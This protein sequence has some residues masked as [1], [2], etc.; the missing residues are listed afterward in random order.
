M[1]SSGRYYWY[2]NVVPFFAMVAVECFSVGSSV[3]FKAATEKGLSYY[4]F[5]AYSYAISTFILLL[6]FP[7]IFFATRSSGLPTFK[8]SLV[9]RIFLLGLIGFIFQLIGYKGLEFSSPT[10]ASALSNLIPAFTYVLAILFR[11]EKATLKSSSTQAKIIGSIVSIIGALVVTLY[12]GPIVLSASAS[13]SS[14]LS[15]SSSQGDWVLGAFLLAAS[16]TL[17]PLWFIV[18]TQVMEQ[19]PVELVVVFLYNLCGTLISAPACI[20]VESSFSVWRL[21]LDITLLAVIFSG[22]CGCL[23]S[24]VHTW[25]IHLKGPVYVSTFKPLSVVIA[26]AM[27][28]IFLGDA[29]YIGSVIGAGI[30]SIG[31]YAV[32][33]GKAKSSAELSEEYCLNRKLTCNSTTPLLNNQQGKQSFP[34]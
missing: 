17:P 11:M 29:L 21:K 16:Y 5:I 31:F 19:Y 12:K 9:G 34:I 10:L 24:V 32:L 2:M 6:P 23:V 22:F 26:A 3:L 20:L 30:L 14:L 8:A 25:A 18:Q 15:S 33:W 7:F 4:V 27:S 13:S 28:V 1:A